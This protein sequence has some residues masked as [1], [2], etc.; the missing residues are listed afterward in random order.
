MAEAI[1][2]DD[3]YIAGYA[4]AVLEHEFNVPGA[5]LQ[6]QQGIV[7]V[8]ADSL[9]NV[10]QKKVIAT[11]E[12]IPGVVR[13]EIQEGTL[14][15]VPPV[16]LQAAVQKEVPK[17][18]SKF[19]PRGLLVAPFHADPRWPHFS[20]ASRHPSYGQEPSH[21]GSANFGETFALYRNAAPFAGQWEIAVQAGVFSIFN[22]NG[23]SNDLVNADYTVGLLSSYRT[24]PL[25]GFIRLHHQSSHLGDEFILNSQIP[26]NRVNVS[27]EEVDL[28]ISYELTSWF[29]I[30]GG[31]GVIFHGE[32]QSIKGGT[33]QGGA[34]LT[35]PWTFWDG[36]IRPVA[37]TDFQ[38][39]EGNNWKVGSSVMTGLQFENAL[40]GDRKVQVL[41]EYFAGPS[42]NGQFYGQNIEWYGVGVHLYY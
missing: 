38:A 9:G 13:A 18:E 22:M 28:K 12:K 21:T 2:V 35:S 17:P 31:G 4:A 36:K 25:S 33:G 1:A 7:I 42:P 34:E 37:Y 6:V 27:Y 11:L 32:P 29:R 23:G 5:V 39:K 26:V 19:L 16:P 40:I 14:P 10:D 8:T 20:L 15:P 3:A 30:Y 24:G 41:A